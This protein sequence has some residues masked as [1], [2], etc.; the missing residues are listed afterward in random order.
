MPK[1][2]F[3]I[4]ILFSLLCACDQSIKNPDLDMNTMADN[5]RDATYIESIEI[6]IDAKVNQNLVFY[7]INILILDNN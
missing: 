1:H 5:Y 4:V 7:H 2:N 3:Y 6:D